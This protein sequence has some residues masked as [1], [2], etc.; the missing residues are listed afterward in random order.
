MKRASAAIAV[1]VCAVPLIA[2]QNDSRT[3]SLEGAGVPRIANGTL[4]QQPLNGPLSSA[5]GQIAR[6]TDSPVWAGYG[7]PAAMLKPNLLSDRGWGAECSLEQSGDRYLSSDRIA[8]GPP[9]LD[10]FIFVRFERGQA[11]RVRSLRSDCSVDAAGT[12][13]HWLTG[14]LSGESIAYLLTLA[15]S[16]NARSFAASAIAA[17]AFHADPAADLAL[18]RLVSAGQ[19]RPLRDNAAFWIGA[20][21]TPHGIDALRRLAREDMDEGFRRYLTFPLSIASGDVALQELI[22]MAHNDAAPGVRG[23]ALFWMAQKAGAKTAAE[24]ASSL[25][26][27]PDTEVKK[28]AVFALSQIP[29]GDGVPKLIE[30]AR[31]NRNAMVRKQAVFW[32][33]QSHDAR[34]L[35]FIEE[36]LTH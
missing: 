1:I 3:V 17:I 12:S 31:T 4:N 13:V 28:R 14:V 6:S 10:L 32:L 23:Q 18:D 27:D 34:A 21:S 35:S 36:I 16:D 19:P 26:N 33:G 5:M 30:V 9:A 20:G 29:H 15:L 22:R 8:T 11:T 7:I 25:E 24:I 2:A